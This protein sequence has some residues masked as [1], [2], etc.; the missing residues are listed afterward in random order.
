[1]VKGVLQWVVHATVVKE[2]NIYYEPTSFDP[3]PFSVEVNCQTV[4][5]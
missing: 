1:M 3:M 5:Y 4:I 2:P